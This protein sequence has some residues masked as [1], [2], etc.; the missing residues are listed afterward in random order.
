MIQLTIQ[1]TEIYSILEKLSSIQPDNSEYPAG[2]HIVRFCHYPAGLSIAL[3]SDITLVY[4]LE[5]LLEQKNIAAV[6]SKPSYWL[7]R[8]RNTGLQSNLVEI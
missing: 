7:S 5:Y 2:Y 4:H 6:G 1:L 8:F 3:S